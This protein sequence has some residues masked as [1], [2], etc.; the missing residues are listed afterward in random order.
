MK[1]IL[2]SCIALLTLFAMT[3]AN[4]SE[5]IEDNA[6]KSMTVKIKVI[7]NDATI[8]NSKETTIFDWNSDAK[9]YD[10]CAAVKTHLKIR[11]N[12]LKAEWLEK[13]KAAGFGAEKK[14]WERDWFLIVVFFLLLIIL[15]IGLEFRRKDAGKAN[16]KNDNI[17]YLQS[18][19]ILYLLG[20]ILYTLLFYVVPVS[21]DNLI[22]SIEVRIIISIIIILDCFLNI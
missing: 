13:E 3:S 19:R 9:T 22:D 15:V 21:T 17:D 10:D 1:Q 5:V 20:A 4:F 16:R 6:T 7:S 2:I 14:F 18:T 12:E 11:T 8:N